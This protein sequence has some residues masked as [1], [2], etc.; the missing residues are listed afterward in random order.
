MGDL[1]EEFVFLSFESV[2]SLIEEGSLFAHPFSLI[3]SLPS[4]ASLDNDESI[5]DNRNLENKSP[6]DLL[7]ASRLAAEILQEPFLRK[8]KKDNNKGIG[9]NKEPKAIAED[10]EEPKDVMEIWNKPYG[11]FFLP[12]EKIPLV[13]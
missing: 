13:Q 11:W 2:A 4:P 1:R 12:G 7:L 8:E 9:R 6:F 3:S 10:K 5:I